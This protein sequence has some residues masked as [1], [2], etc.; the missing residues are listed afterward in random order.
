MLNCMDPALDAVAD[1]FPDF[2]EGLR[3]LAVLIARA[4]RSRSL[5]MGAALEVPP[6]VSEESEGAPAD[7]PEP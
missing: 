5:R 4:H 6:Y 3:L 7:D 1:E 2:P